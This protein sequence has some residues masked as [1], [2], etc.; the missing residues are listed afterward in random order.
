M[1]IYHRE[2]REMQCP[3]CGM[4]FHSHRP[5]IMI[6]HVGDEQDTHTIIEQ[7]VKND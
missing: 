6:V 5:I 4:E 7:E 1:T 3:V 2:D